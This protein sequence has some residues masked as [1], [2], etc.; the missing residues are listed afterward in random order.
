MGNSREIGNSREMIHQPSKSQISNSRNPNPNQGPS[1]G[2]GNNFD[3]YE[4]VGDNEV[5]KPTTSFP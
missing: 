4:L 1:T 2:Q 5:Y 3:E